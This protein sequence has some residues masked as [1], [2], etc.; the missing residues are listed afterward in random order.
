M[1]N[2]V[3]VFAKQNLPSHR[4][5]LFVLSFFFAGVSPLCLP[6]TARADGFE[7]AA[8]SLARK[9][10]AAPLQLEVA[11][12][13]SYGGAL[14][15]EMS[16]LS[17]S[18]DP[19]EWTSG[20]AQPG[21]EKLAG[22]VF[23]R[24]VAL[25]NYGRFQPQLAAAWRHDADAR[26][27]QFALRPDVTFSDGTPL[28]PA[29]VVAALEPLLPSGRRIFASGSDVTVESSAAMPDL[30][31]ELASGRNFI[32]R[33]E[34][35]GALFG[36]GTF[37]LADSSSATHLV[38]R[39]HENCWAGRPFLDAIEVTL[40]V[41]PLR[42]LYD[43]Q[44]GKADLIELAP[45]V[46]RRATQAGLRTWSSD[47][48]ELVALV[49]NDQLAATQDA[50]LRRALVLSLDRA[51]MASVLL[52]KQAVPAG[53]LL[54]QWLSGYAFLF[55][56][57]TN[58]TAAKEIRSA[59]PVKLAS[60]AEPLRL[61]VD[62]GDDLSR[63][64]AERVAVNARQA[65]L[66]VQVQSRSG[67]RPTPGTAAP[68]PPAVRLVRLRVASLAPRAALS[69]LVAALGLR[70]PSSL[71]PSAE[72][73][74]LY[75]RERAFVDTGYVIP[76]VYIPESVGLSANVRDWMPTPWGEWRLADVWLDLPR[77]PPKESSSGTAATSETGDAGA[78]P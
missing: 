72:P 2:L 34:P 47:P 22:L 7:D 25:D 39:A 37:V 26:R 4:R 12:R 67:T 49:V 66:I 41:P 27:W 17:I 50:Q 57:E 30:L 18:L 11:R 78:R 48:V 63:L 6:P 40:A 21:A 62:S 68:P 24:L 38:F 16:A 76:L 71:S 28:T 56:V 45:D 75:E 74:Q 35:G 19:R 52:Q 42:Q 33:A 1:M 51:T 44:L 13:P 14:R 73:E 70:E 60:L 10:A 53:A 61:R 23:D 36:T 55:S 69:A 5:F 3:S 46:L 64:I 54:P 15:M 9:V 65:G 29:S 77:T 58:G 59:L 20:A 31:E 32:Y 43:L 8:R